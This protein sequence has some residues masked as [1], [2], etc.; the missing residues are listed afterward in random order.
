M[1]GAG[2]GGQ[3]EAAAGEGGLA[4]ACARVE[5]ACA[6]VGRALSWLVLPLM[7]S[8]LA[9][10]ATA[11]LRLNEVVRWDTPVPLLGEAITGNTLLDLQWALFLL[12]VMFGGSYAL[13]ADAHVKVDLL[14]TAFSRRARLAV[15]LAGDLVL[16]LPF[17]V[18]MTWYGWDFAARAYRSGE[19]S[20]YGGLVDLWIVKAALPVAFALLAVM[21]VARIV[22]A[23]A[24]LVSGRTDGRGA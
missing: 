9:T 11:Q 12:L 18:L 24:A 5:G 2:S 17:A 1:A 8:V 13:A 10:I 6:A 19:G 7:A 14:S 3:A 4:R 16:L 23:A 20:T 22:R 21:T 15:Q